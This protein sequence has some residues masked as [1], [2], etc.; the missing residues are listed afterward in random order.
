MHMYMRP[1]LWAGKPNDI[2]FMLQFYNFIKV[3]MDGPFVLFTNIWV[4]SLSGTGW[5]G[6]FHLGQWRLS[7]HSSKYT[8]IT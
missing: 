6:D 4:L 2:D 8:V 3:F 5:T 7:K 1:P